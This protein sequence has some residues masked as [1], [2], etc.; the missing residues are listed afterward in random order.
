MMSASPRI[1][2]RGVRL[3]VVRAD[4]APRADVAEPHDLRGPDELADLDLS[5]VRAPSIM[6]AAVSVYVAVSGRDA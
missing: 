5:S 6:W 1:E 3:E 2:H 4:Q